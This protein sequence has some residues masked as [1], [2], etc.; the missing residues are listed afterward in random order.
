VLVAY[1]CERLARGE[2]GLSVAAPWLAAFGF[3]LLHGFGVAGA[4]SQIG[5]PENA[6]VVALLL[7][8]VGVEIGQV[9]VVVLL[10][11]PLA[12]FRSRSVPIRRLRLFGG[13]ILGSAGAFWLIQRLSGAFLPVGFATGAG[14]V[15]DAREWTNAWPAGAPKGHDA[16]RDLARRK[17]EPV[18]RSELR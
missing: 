1:E 6:R 2:S 4:L 7:F 18:T 14:E 16:D 8:N 17:L 3:G 9:A 5:L 12:W 15:K 13:Y 11:A 10:A